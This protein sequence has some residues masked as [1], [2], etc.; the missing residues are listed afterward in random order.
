M[1]E[2]RHVGICLTFPRNGYRVVSVEAWPQMNTEGSDMAAGFVGMD[3]AQGQQL[4]QN[5]KTGGADL[6]AAVRKLDSFVQASEGF[7]KGDGANKFRAEW[8][9]FKPQAQKMITTI[10]ADAPQAVQAAVNAIGQATG[11]S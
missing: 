4:A 8:Q 9:Q 1:L 3:L 2:Q 10:Q 5:F 7:W 6:E 11:V